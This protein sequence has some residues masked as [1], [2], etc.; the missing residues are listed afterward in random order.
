MAAQHLNK[1]LHIGFDL[2]CDPSVFSEEAI[3]STQGSKL[4]KSRGSLT[5][6]K[7]YVAKIGREAETGSSQDL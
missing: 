2:I 7:G 1:T 3:C 5:E 6:T 4:D